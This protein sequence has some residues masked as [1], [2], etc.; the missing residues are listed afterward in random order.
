MIGSIP[1]LWGFT[2]LVSRDDIH[3]FGVV[4]VDL[5]AVIELCSVQ[6]DVIPIT[7]SLVAA[8]GYSATLMML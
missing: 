8:V 7:V 5:R 4:P 3:H 6:S 2:K 1:L